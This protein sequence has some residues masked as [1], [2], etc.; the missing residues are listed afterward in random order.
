MEPVEQPAY[1]VA[2]ES[3]LEICTALRDE[4]EFGFDTAYRCLCGVDLSDIR[5]E[6]VANA[7]ARPTAV[8][9]VA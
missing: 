4:P 1:V 9:A 3:L 8:S 7:D 6:R 5:T 2:K